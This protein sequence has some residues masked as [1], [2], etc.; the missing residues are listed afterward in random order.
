MNVDSLER[1]VPD[2][3]H[4]GESTGDETLRLHLERYAFAARYAR[5]RVLD[6]ACGVGYGSALLMERVPAIE[7]IVG[8]DLSADAIAMANQR[9]AHPR[10]AFVQA[11]AKR[12]RCEPVDTIVSLETIEHVPGPDELVAHLVSLLK[13]GGCLV[14]SV[15]STPSV[16][17][18]PHHL[19][20]FTERS[21]RAMFTTRGC[22]ELDVLRQVQ[23]FSPVRIVRRQERRMQSMRKNLLGYYLQHPGAVVRRAWSTLVDGFANRYVTI[24]WRRD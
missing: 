13:P 20:D 21:F 22:T 11:D 12:F 14:A 8:V 2:E 16:D 15:P 9:Y 18:N 10:I 7:G 17:A 24:V 5:G 6:M 3:L 1:I 23:P 19:T 4:D